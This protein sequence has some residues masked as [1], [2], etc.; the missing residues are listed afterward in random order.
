[1]PLLVAILV[2]RSRNS[3]T[4]VDLFEDGFHGSR[5]DEGLGVGIVGL[6]VTVDGD[7]KLAYAGKRSATDGAVGELAE[8]DL[9]QV[10][11]ARAGGPEVVVEARSARQPGLAPGHAG[12][13]GV[14]EDEMEVQDPWVAQA[15]P[16]QVPTD[17]P[18]GVL[19]A[20]RHTGPGLGKVSA[21]K[22]AWL[23]R[24]DPT[25]KGLVAA[26]A[27]P[28]AEAKAMQHELHLHI[29]ETYRIH[30][31]ML[32]TRRRWLTGAHK[33]FVRDVVESVE[34]A[35]DEAPHLTPR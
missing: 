25:V 8:P 27:K 26:L 21:G 16:Q 12:S 19:A 17:P 10:Q 1:M 28:G 11:P 3:S 23:V 14:V 35:L 4:T 6:D 22:L 29:S 33:R 34:M 13:A 7:P 5:P 15:W 31:R 9:G 18:G 20:G 32:R 30:R 2:L 24:N